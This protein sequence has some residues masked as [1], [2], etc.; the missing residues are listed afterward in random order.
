[1]IITKIILK[2]KTK[3]PLLRQFFFFPQYRIFQVILHKKD[4]NVTSSMIN[5]KLIKKQKI[6]FCH[7]ERY[8]T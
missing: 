4:W 7:K 6:K 5:K 8:K 1:M 3:L 2:Y